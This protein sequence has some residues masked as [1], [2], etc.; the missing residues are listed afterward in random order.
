MQTEGIRM[1]R[2]I[3]DLREILHNRKLSLDELRS[4][5]DAKLRALIAHACGTCSILPIAFSVSRTLPQ[6]YPD[7]LMN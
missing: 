6:R 3:A 1:I 5:Q 2:E 4:L 7:E